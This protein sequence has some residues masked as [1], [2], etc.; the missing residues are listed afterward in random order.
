MSIKDYASALGE[1]IGKMAEEAIKSF[2][3]QLAQT[4]DI[5]IGQRK[6]FD[7]VGIDFEIDLPIVKNNN[8]IALIDIKYLRYKKHA[9]DKSSWVVVAHNRLKATFPSIKRNL[10]ILLGTG[11]TEQAKKLIYTSCSDIIEIEPNILNEILSKYGIEFVW[12]EKDT[13]TPKKSWEKFFT[14]SEDKKDAIKKEI[15]EKTGIKQQIESWFKQYVLDDDSNEK[16]K[17][18]YI[19]DKNR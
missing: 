10:V 9:R 3:E 19:C 18:N 2:I 6:Y 1:A 16:I 8:L 12:D 4:Y 14:L 11:W 15:L 7:K 17:L 5:K 13:E